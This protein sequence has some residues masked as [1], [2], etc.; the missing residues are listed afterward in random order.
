MEQRENLGGLSPGAA[1]TAPGHV[2]STGS[3]GG[4]NAITFRNKFRIYHFTS[5]V[6]KQELLI[7]AS[8]PRAMAEI[9]IL[10][11]PPGETLYT[12]LKYALLHRPI[13]PEHRRNQY[14]L[15]AWEPPCN[16]VSTQ[17]AAPA[18]GPPELLGDIHTT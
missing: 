10:V 15:R 4:I 7:E 13:L 2:S 17:P 12:T 6:R 16:T 1:A 5:E 3:V 8:P 9:H 14:Q 18:W 11:G